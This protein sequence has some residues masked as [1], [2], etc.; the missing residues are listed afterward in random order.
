MPTYL[1]ETESVWQVRQTKGRSVAQYLSPD[2]ARIAHYPA[3]GCEVIYEE[4]QP[5]DHS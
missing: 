2:D 4:E 1:K 5:N 3:T